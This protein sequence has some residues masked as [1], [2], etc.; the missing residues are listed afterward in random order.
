MSCWL[1][2]GSQN[3]QAYDGSSY[4]DSLPLFWRARYRHPQVPSDPLA[5][6]E[7]DEV[8]N[9][10]ALQPIYYCVSWLRRTAISPIETKA[11]SLKAYVTVYGTSDSGAQDVKCVCVWSVCSL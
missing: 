11:E 2:A 8:V 9:T 6:V 5:P 1:Q 4:F 10:F 7:K 3:N